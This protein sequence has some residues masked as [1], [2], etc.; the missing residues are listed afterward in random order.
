MSSQSKLINFI[1]IHWTTDRE[2][3]NQRTRSSVPHILKAQVGMKPYGLHRAQPTVLHDCRDFAETGGYNAVSIGSLPSGDKVI[4]SIFGFNHRIQKRFRWFF[5]GKKLDR[6]VHH[7]GGKIP[8][9][10]T[11]RLERQKLLSAAASGAIHGNCLDL[12]V[13]GSSAPNSV[14]PPIEIPNPPIVL[15]SAFVRR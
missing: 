4:C 15:T 1:F 14:S 13:A 2:G 7:P 3:L 6:C 5:S 10:W 11:F 9:Q 12:W 8:D